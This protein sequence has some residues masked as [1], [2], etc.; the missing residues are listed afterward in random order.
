[1]CAAEA[2]QLSRMPGVPVN[3]C[4]RPFPQK[5]TFKLQSNT[6]YFINSHV[7]GLPEHPGQAPPGQAP[8]P[9]ACGG[10]VRH[11]GEDRVH[12]AVHHRHPVRAD[13]A[14]PRHPPSR[15]PPAHAPRPPTAHK[16][17]PHTLLA[18]SMT[19]PPCSPSTSSIIHETQ[20]PAPICL[21]RVFGLSFCT[22]QTQK[23]YHSGHFM[24]ANYV[25]P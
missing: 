1:M 8:P 24:L 6:N 12:P 5:M 20:G 11:A 19:T 4:P 13:V 22:S 2:P 10:A 15:G 25:V 17:G 16:R 9:P 21:P 18:V 23:L 7:W 3:P 14:A